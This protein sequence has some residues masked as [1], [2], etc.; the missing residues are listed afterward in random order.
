MRRYM[1]GGAKQKQQSYTWGAAEAQG[2][3][4]Y[5]EDAWT[6]GVYIRPL[7]SSA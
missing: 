5:M 6:A 3:R 4:D 2:P 1:L 7:L